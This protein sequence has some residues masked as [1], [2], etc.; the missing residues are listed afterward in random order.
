[1]YIRHLTGP[2]KGEVEELEFEAARGKVERGEA[3]DVFGTL[4][5]QRRGAV[6][7]PPVVSERIDA[8]DILQVTL[9]RKR[10]RR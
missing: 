9:P 10:K 3:E 2:R 1:M 8:T 4:D 5:I 7:S 6:V